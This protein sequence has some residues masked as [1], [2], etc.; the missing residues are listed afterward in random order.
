M[1]DRT[2]LQE[3]LQYCPITGN[4]TWKLQVSNVVKVGAIAGCID[5][6][7]YRVISLGG[8]THKAHRLAFL[9]MTGKLPKVV[10]HINGV[11]D[12]NRWENLRVSTHLS[13]NHNRKKQSNAS[14]NIKGLSYYDTYKFKG[15]L[16]RI[17]YDY[18][19]LSKAFSIAAYGDKATAEKAAIEWIITTR[20]ELHGDFANHG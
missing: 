15:F 11:K 6:L 5:K 4:F 1:I 10:D 19:R 20:E 8:F 2:Y 17:S 12:D 14:T 16:A 13:N 3:C 7:G 18:K 9:Y